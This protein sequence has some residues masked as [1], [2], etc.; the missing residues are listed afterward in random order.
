MGFPSKIDSI[1]RESG[2]EER[3][4]QSYLAGSLEN[5]AQSA[6]IHSRPHSICI[7]L[8]NPAPHQMASTLPTRTSL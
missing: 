6:H 5:L 4:H 7:E 8:G 3:D 2:A 1:D